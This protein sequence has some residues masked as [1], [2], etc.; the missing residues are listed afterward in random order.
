VTQYTLPADGTASAKGAST[1]SVPSAPSGAVF[2]VLINGEQLGTMIGATPFGTIQLQNSDTL[3]L[4]GTGLLPGQQYQAQVIGSL[5]YGQ[6]G[7]IV[8]TPQ[9]TA[10]LSSSPPDLIFSGTVTLPTSGTVSL[11]GITMPAPYQ[12]IMAVIENSGNTSFAALENSSNGGF[13]GFNSPIAVNPIISGAGSTFI[14]PMVNEPGDQADILFDT[15]GTGGVCPILVFGVRSVMA[16]Q[17]SSDPVGGLVVTN[18]PSVPI[19]VIPYGGTLQEQAVITTG[20]TV[21]LAAPA[22]GKSYR[23]QRVVYRESSAFE[24]ILV[25]H[26]SGFVYSAFT[27]VAS[28]LDNVDN[29]DGLIATEAL[30]WVTGGGSTGVYLAYD[31][32]TT[33]TVQ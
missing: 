7:A 30:D 1:V 18:S 14:W 10:V 21:A 25:G 19:E 5:N 26:T 23:L 17:V 12:S 29:M 15:S 9:A 22:A 24:V 8:P 6:V 20:T 28:N 4:T 16:V 27:G 32:A 13:F 33:P 31:I 3:S 11:P 2:A